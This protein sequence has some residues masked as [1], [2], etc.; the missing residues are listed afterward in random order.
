MK[1]ETILIFFDWFDPAI[2]AGGPVTSLRNLTNSLNK[3]FTFFIYTGSKEYGTDKMLEVGSCNEWIFYAE[4]VK[5]F[6][7]VNP[8]FYEINQIFNTVNPNT[9][10]LNGVYSYRFSI[11]PLIISK[12]K[13]VRT[14]ISPRGMLST[15]S[16]NVKQLKKKVFLWFMT[17]F[18]AYH[19]IE[20]HATSKNEELDIRKVV[21]GDCLISTIPNIPRK[22]VRSWM[23]KAKKKGE[24]NMLFIGRISPEKNLLLAL[25]LLSETDSNV[26]MGILGASYDMKYEEKCKFFISNN[27]LQNRVKF[28][29]AVQSNEMATFYQKYHIMVLP[30]TGENFGHAI[31]ES[32]SEGLPVI[33]SD[34]T[35]WRELEKGRCGLNLKLKD[36]E[37]WARAI[38]EFKQMDQDEFGIWSR[39]A[40]N[41]AREEFNNIADIESYIRLFKGK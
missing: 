34:L 27:K 6:Y 9:V 29:G 21:G 14:I 35:P 18:H 17:F 39:N 38:N 37:G 11:I 16:M 33:I 19:R 25:K 8:G 10:Y 4:N 15:G 20:F 28:Y 22:N 3:N 12:L 41:Y 40:Y 2:K 1:N 32:L 23:S 31:F 36:V 30:T 24:L 13:G 5:V 7:S 26:H